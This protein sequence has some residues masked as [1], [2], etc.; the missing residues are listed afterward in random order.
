MARILHSSMRREKSRSR[1][2]PAAPRAQVNTPRCCTSRTFN[3]WTW[4]GKL[5]AVGR[6]GSTT[7][8]FTSL[9]GVGGR[10]G[11]SIP[12]V[13]V[14][15]AK[16]SCKCTLRSRYA[17][18]PPLFHPLPRRYLPLPTPPHNCARSGRVAGVCPF[19]AAVATRSS[20]QPARHTKHY[21]CAAA[22]ALR[23]QLCALLWM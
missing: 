6:A 3:R 9:A 18:L 7:A 20:T 10:C 5:R 13:S 12:F 2:S 21:L 8:G 19:L 17:Y 4:T 1:C 15:Y 16:N 11:G 23:A 14:A 22:L